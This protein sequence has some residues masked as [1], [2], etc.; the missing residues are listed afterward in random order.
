MINPL[1]LITQQKS[2]NPR[3]TLLQTHL[4]IYPEFDAVE[5]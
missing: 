2:F 4:K 5:S 3:L 1:Y